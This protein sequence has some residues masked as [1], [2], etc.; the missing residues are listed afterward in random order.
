MLAA[1]T[2]P[3]IGR[4]APSLTAI[5]SRLRQIADHIEA[6]EIVAPLAEVT[7]ALG[8]AAAEDLSPRQW[9]IVQRLIRGERV[10]TIAAAM[11]LSASTIRNHLT[12]VFAKVGV[13]SQEESSRCTTE[14][15]TTRPQ[16]DR[17]T[18]R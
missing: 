9:E 2:E 11:Y 6:A 5:P 7:D 3:E 14:V 17:E 1:E 4:A 10:T 13:H 15:D 18:S 12:A 8:L 16:A